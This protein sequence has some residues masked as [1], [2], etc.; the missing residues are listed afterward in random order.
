MKVFP[1]LRTLWQ[2]FGRNRNVDALHLLLNTFLFLICG[3]GPL[4]F[5]S[6]CVRVF[7][8]SWIVRNEHAAIF[9]EDQWSRQSATINIVRGL[10][11]YLLVV[12]QHGN[13]GSFDLAIQKR[14]AGNKHRLGR[15]NPVMLSLCLEPR[16]PIDYFHTTI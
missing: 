2:D 7:T 1:H 10:A 9:L 14:D 12:S 5:S 3:G 13:A 6:H 16:A 11:V 15:G 4:D 8:H